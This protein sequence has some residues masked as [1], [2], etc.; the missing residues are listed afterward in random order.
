[1]V[2]PDYYFAFSKNARLVWLRTDRD[3]YCIKVK[4]DGKKEL[5]NLFDSFESLLKNLEN[6]LIEKIDW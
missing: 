1:M 5:D 2:E 6:D 3:A 4:G